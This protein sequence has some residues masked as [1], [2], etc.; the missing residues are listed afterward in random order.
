MAWLH[1]W[2]GLLVGW[3]LY[4]IFLTGTIGY[5]D[6]EIDRWMRPELPLVQSTVTQ[7]EGL[8]IAFERL[9]R[10]APTASQWT[11]YPPTGH[12]VPNINVSWA[13][14]GAGWRSE[15]LGPATGEPL[16]ARATG[17]G[18]ALYQ[19]HYV[20]RYMPMSVAYWVV[21][22]C[23]MLMLT[24][25][26]T[27]IITHRRIFRDFFTFRPGRGQR[28]WLDL[29]NVFGVFALPFHLMIT[30]SGLVFFV[31]T[32]M[33]LVVAATYGGGNEDR[34]RFFDEALQS[35]AVPAAAGVEA[36]L[37]TWS[38]MID[39]AEARWG[40]GGIRSVDVRHPGDANARVVFTRS[41]STPISNGGRIVF[42]GASGRMLEHYDTR[43]GATAVN[44]ALLGLHEGLF[45]GPALRWLYF[46]SGVLGT[47]MI[48]SGLVLWTVKRRAQAPHPGL[49]IVERLNV[50]TIA[51]LLTAVAAYFWANRLLPVGLEARAD[52]EMDILFAVWGL[53][54]VHAA[55][56]PR[57]RAW[58][59][60]CV[61]GAVAFGLLPV[62]NALTSG[63]GLTAS[64]PAGEWAVAGVDLV[65][66]V[67]AACFVV[68]AL[69][70]RRP[71]PSPAESAPALRPGQGRSADRLT[72]N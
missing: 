64:L 17:G 20:L 37:A 19:L 26:V 3:V 7:R 35:P 58:I 32:Y 55:F 34:N 45:A 12:D 15:V 68:A 51:G 23:S 48:G 33:S 40:E 43:S 63:Y 4:F 13:V 59:E 28:S 44:D 50:G 52:A 21:G 49:A 42:D 1:T 31:F 14:P 39:Q 16:E 69:R 8:D 25:L 29:H 53:L 18:Q 54:L 60:Q 71:A 41:H 57:H 56:R 47:A 11:V 67:L 5:F 61:I 65:C 10:V 22:V 46:L 62:V 36:P 24:A 70:L 9:A 72:V 38:G 66:L 27:G 30:Y 6:S 2:S